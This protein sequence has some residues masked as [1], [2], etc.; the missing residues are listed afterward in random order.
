MV[1][2]QGRKRLGT[3]VRVERQETAGKK[4]GGAA[5]PAVLRGASCAR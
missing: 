5:T 1:G 4:G 2:C 3:Q